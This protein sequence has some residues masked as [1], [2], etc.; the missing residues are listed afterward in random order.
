MVGRDQ[1]SI[2]FIS[3]LDSDIVQNLGV[4]FARKLF[5]LFS[6]LKEMKKSNIDSNKLDVQF[7]FAKD[8]QK[9]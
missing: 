7:N 4:L 9:F 8:E 2:D 3:D 1:D 6:S 5:Y